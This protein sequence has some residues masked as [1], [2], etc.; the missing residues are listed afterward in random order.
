MLG[1][2][3]TATVGNPGNPFLIQ[4]YFQYR[5]E[6]S[7][8][9]ATNAA[10]N[11]ATTLFNLFSGL[12]TNRL[13]GDLGQVRFGAG[14]SPALIKQK[15]I[16]AGAHVNKVLGNHDLKFGWDFQQT[17]V[18]G[19]E[20]TNQLNQLFAT[21]SDFEQFGPV[22][23]GV[24]VLSR[25][26]GPTPAD[27]II[28]LRNFYNGLFAQD[29]WK[30]ARNLTLNVGLRWDGD[31]RFAN[32]GNFSPRLGV[33]WSPTPKTVINASWGMFYDRFRLG[34]ARDIP[35]L[36]GA[37]LF[38]NQT[39]SYPRLF[40]GNPSTLPRLFGL[41]PS[42]NL[43]D[44]QIQA[45]GAVCPIA[46]LAFVGIDHLN[47]VVA[48]GHALI[49]AN[50]VVTMNNVQAFTGLSSQQFADAASAAVGRQPGFFFWGSLGHLTMNFPV[51]RIFLLPITLDPRL[52]TPHTRN[53]HLGLQRELT[54][55][56]VVQ[57]DYYHRDIRDMLGVRVSNLAFEARLPGHSGQLQPGTG[58]LPILSY[59]PW[60]QG[61]YDGLSIGVSKRMSNRFTFETFYTWARM[62]DNAL[63][64]SFVSDVQTG[65]GA[66][67]LGSYGQTDSFVGV[68]PVVTDPVTGQ[69]NAN[70]SFIASNGN[71]IP[72][73]GLFYD[74]ANL[75]RGPSDLAFN[76]TLLMHG[77]VNL[78]WRLAVS[79]IFR[80]QSGFH[81]SIAAATPV[82]VDGDGL[83]NGVD[84]L[85]GR[86]HFV[87]PAY[88][89]VD[90]RLSKRFSI[91]EKVHAQFIFE[92][93]NLLN[94]ANPAAVQQF[95]NLSIPV[96]K[97]LQS[98]PGREGQIGVRIDF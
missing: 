58:D 51:P 48:P 61:S 83:L 79:G 78:P 82:D 13:F 74:G 81:F 72:Q 10:S 54:T 15:Y 94:R 87:A 44:S 65:R 16:S 95:Q 75:D 1:A 22:N 9:R 47:A 93:F 45:S 21:V 90:L 8:L 11:P 34:L 33:A 89:N 50:A 97:T 66:G 96:G 59:G 88:A 43:T 39:I 18:D 19:L 6:P 63:N 98:L 29:D 37:N 84:F 36:G 73:A 60:S 80:A 27:N 91:R 32:G 3:D 67:S 41:C 86:N 28:R 26:S 57:A 49:P 31:S 55:N 25:V 12:T 77:T 52:K 17:R 30:I 4:A 53:F 62:M 2:R 69:T 70:G 68:P 23:A 46:G 76:H 64:S 40:Y 5:A 56:L 85:A 14:F 24:Y 71:P 7:L 92:F 38:R 20:A 42:T 35:A